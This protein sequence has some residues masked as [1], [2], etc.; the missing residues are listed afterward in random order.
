MAHSTFHSEVNPRL[1]EN[2]CDEPEASL[3]PLEDY[4]LVDL[5]SLE[6]ASEPINSHF[7]NVPRDVWIAKNASKK[8]A[9]G[10]TVDE[11]AAIHLYTMEI[12]DQPLY[13]LLNKLL[14]DRDRRKLKE[15]FS[16]L[17]LFLTALYKLPPCSAKVI[18]RGVKADVQAKYHTG[19]HY[20]WWA[21]SS[22]TLSLQALEQP[23]Y[24][25]TTGPRTLFSIE[26]F[27][28]KD[29]K[30]HSYYKEE[31]EVLLLPGFYFKVVGKVQVGNGLHIIQLREVTPPFALLEPP[32]DV[33]RPI[34]TSSVTSDVSEIINEI[35]NINKNNDIMYKLFVVLPDP[36][37]KWDCENVFANQLVIHF[38][39]EC[40]TQDL[41]F[42]CAV[43][44]AVPNTRVF[45]QIYGHYMKQFMLPLGQ[46]LYNRQTTDRCHNAQFWNDFR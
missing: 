40:A 10:L 9:D 45:F 2:T 29:I 41:H 35:Y 8:P 6:K 33:H 43:P 22:C 24:L 20:T 28:G 12:K 19:E 26:C 38:V 23:M 11:S 18:W 16:Y 27:N 14:R 13:S 1:T 5:V 17:K 31:D 39:C 46:H 7:R 36:V 37:F 30:S 42:V 4:Q 44:H 25:G 32:F 15:W 21:F 3:M 34:C